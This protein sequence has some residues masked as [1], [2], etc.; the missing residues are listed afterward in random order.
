MNESV[1]VLDSV[2]V[3]IVDDI[4]GVLGCDQLI[5]LY[6]AASVHVQLLFH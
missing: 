2:G 6:R 1:E 3:Q 4:E 5:S